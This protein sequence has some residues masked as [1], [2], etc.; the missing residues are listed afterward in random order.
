MPSN[1]DV[2]LWI[3]TVYDISVIA[4]YSCIFYAIEVKYVSDMVI[5]KK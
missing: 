4:V 3:I 5:E 2:T 1:A